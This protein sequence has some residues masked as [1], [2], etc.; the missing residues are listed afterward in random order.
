MKSI[1]QKWVVRLLICL[2][3]IGWSSIPIYMR[4]EA[5]SSVAPVVIF[6]PKSEYKKNRPIHV[7]MLITNPFSR[8]ITIHRSNFGL[9]EIG[10]AEGLYIY[11]DKLRAKCCSHYVSNTMICGM[12]VI[13]LQ[14]QQSVAEAI[15]IPVE[16]ELSLGPH[17]ILYELRIPFYGNEKQFLMVPGQTIVIYDDP[18]DRPIIDDWRDAWHDFINGNGEFTVRGKLEFVVK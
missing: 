18:R 2:I 7:R 17:S 5:S 6:F 12:N 1:P 10:G 11:D 16:A 3:V 13:R 4:H 14:P 8:Q 9:A 15:T